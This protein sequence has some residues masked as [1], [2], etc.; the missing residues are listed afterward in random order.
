MY[1]S[2]SE[3]K[4]NQQA[5]DDAKL[6]VHTLSG[7]GSGH[8]T[9]ALRD[10]EITFNHDLSQTSVIEIV[11]FRKGDDA[12]SNWS[13]IEH[14]RIW[15]H[16]LLPDFV[17]ASKH[18]RVLEPL[19]HDNLQG[20]LLTNLSVRKEVHDLMSIDQGQACKNKG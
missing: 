15:W 20:I 16:I 3:E 13:A 19:G 2:G 10:N 11:E 9:I 1:W 12:A 4:T 8:N 7:T 17:V 14:F 5:V 6:L 18:D